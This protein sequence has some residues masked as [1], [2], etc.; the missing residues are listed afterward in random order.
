ME[1]PNVSIFK[2]GKP[3]ISIFVCDGESIINKVNL[4]KEDIVMITQGKLPY[5][6]IKIGN[7]N[8]IKHVSQEGQEDII[9]PFWTMM[10]NKWDN[11][12]FNSIVNPCT[13]ACEVMS[14]NVLVAKNV[15]ILDGDNIITKDARVSYLDKPH[16]FVIYTDGDRKNRLGNFTTEPTDDGCYCIHTNVTLP[17]SQDLFLSWNSRLVLMQIACRQKKD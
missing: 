4:E 9:K 15:P 1:A 5:A 12:L 13:F 6:A 11:K 16:T 8:R 2:K 14:L 7:N 10:L 17:I 3:S